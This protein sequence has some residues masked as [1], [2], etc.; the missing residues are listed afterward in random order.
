MNETEF[1]FVKV[2]DFLPSYQQDL[3]HI[4][5]LLENSNAFVIRILPHRFVNG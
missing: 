1:E 4:P 3:V 2:Y 5:I